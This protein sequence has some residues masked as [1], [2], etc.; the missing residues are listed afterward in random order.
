MHLPCRSDNKVCFAVVLHLE[1]F[2]FCEQFL[3]NWSI[4]VK[5]Q[6]F[7]VSWKLEYA[8]INCNVLKELLNCK[9]LGS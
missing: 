7:L 6:S 3:H 8:K 1:S 2:T 5:W 9:M 4:K